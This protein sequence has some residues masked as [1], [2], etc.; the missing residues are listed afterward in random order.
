VKTEYIALFCISFLLIPACLSKKNPFEKTEEFVPVVGETNDDEEISP[1]NENENILLDDVSENEADVINDDEYFEEEQE[2][3][4]DHFEEEYS[5][6]DDYPEYEDENEESFDDEPLLPDEE[7]HVDDTETDCPD[8]LGGEECDLCARYCDSTK[9]ESNSSLS[10]EKATSSIQKAINSAQN[11]I[12]ENGGQCTVFLKEGTY[13]I[14][15]TIFMMDDINIYGNGVKE[16]VILDGNFSVPRIIAGASNATLQNITIQNGK[17]TGSAIEDGGGMIVFYA[18]GLKIKNC[19]F[20][21]SYALN[22]GGLHIG[23]NSEVLVTDSLFIDNFSSGKGGA[24]SVDGDS[25]AV[26]DRCIFSDNIAD[27]GGALSI[28]DCGEERVY[29]Y[30][31]LF[32][33]NLAITEGGAVYTSES[34]PF[35]AFSTF[36]KNDSLSGSAIHSQDSGEPFLVGN[37]FSQNSSS[38]QLKGKFFAVYNN[39]HSNEEPT[40]GGTGNINDPPLFVDSEKRNYRLL[41]HSTS[42]NAVPLELDFIESDLEGKPRPQ[43]G[44]Y[45]MGCYEN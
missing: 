25:R 35:F 8:G 7:E 22:G 9:P 45:D 10:P 32:K 40:L 3:E 34:S 1:D 11:H 30:N 41:P 44:A 39:V 23:D 20:K 5:G 26:F 12:N 36:V 16:N 6:D 15:Q 28:E 31:S 17:A 14:D 13:F 42:V 24:V 43:N 27:K 33:D 18:Y 19:I 29:I 38:L 4:E 21:G 2:I 37:I